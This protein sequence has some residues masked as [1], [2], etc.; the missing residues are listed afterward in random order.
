[1]FAHNRRV[2][3]VVLMAPRPDAPAEGLLLG[4]LDS[5]AE[6]DEPIYRDMKRRN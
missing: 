4:E 6:G 1:M 5:D 3:T 2:S